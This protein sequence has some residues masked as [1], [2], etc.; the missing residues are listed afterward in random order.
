MKID[1]LTHHDFSWKQMSDNCNSSAISILSNAQYSCG[2]N[3]LECVINISES[4]CTL[5]KL[6]S[7]LEIMMQN[8]EIKLCGFDYFHKYFKKGQNINLH[9]NHKW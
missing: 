7:Q 4:N 9:L 6:F 8:F 1:C 5:W 3:N 2:R